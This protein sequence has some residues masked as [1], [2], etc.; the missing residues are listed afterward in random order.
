MTEHFRLLSAVI[1]LVLGTWLAFFFF[2][3]ARIVR[4]SAL[5]YLAHLVLC[6]DFL[7]FVYLIVKY[8][9]LNLPDTIPDPT[10]TPLQIIALFT[11]ISL[12]HGMVFSVIRLFFDLRKESIHRPILLWLV[13]SY[14]LI[15][16][17]FV[18][19]LSWFPGSRDFVWLD[20]LQGFL[21]FNLPVLDVTISVKMSRYAG[22]HT[23][24]DETRLIS[25]FGKLHLSR[26]A[27]VIVIFLLIGL[28]FGWRIPEHIAP[29]GAFVALL[30]MNLVPLLW[31]RFTFAPY[32][33][34]LIKVI[35]DPSRLQRLAEDHGLSKREE[36]IMQLLVDGKSNKE[37]QESLFI[38]Y[39]TVKNHIYNLYQ[40]LGVKSRYALLHLIAKTKRSNSGT[41]TTY[42]T[43]K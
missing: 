25:S 4:I 21:Y 32:A 29:F 23:N 11:V 43:N 10:R 27:I 3:K 37:I 36:E 28:C 6:F 20:I 15:V 7:L 22:K 42:Q 8:V 34:S 2:Q 35:D 31:Y 19:R 38:S 9:S 13:V 41:S 18:I 40:K 26:Y 24:E 14:V 33:E 16:I 1:N 30:Y 12:L 5:K 17:S 39:H